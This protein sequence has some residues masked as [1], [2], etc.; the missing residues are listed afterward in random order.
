MDVANFESFFR[1]QES[2]REKFVILTSFSE[3]ISKL[4]QELEDFE[5]QEE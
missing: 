3:T 1:R 5:K 2:I 4:F